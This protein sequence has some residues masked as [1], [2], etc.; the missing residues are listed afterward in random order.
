MINFLGQKLSVEIYRR[1]VVIT[2]LARYQLPHLM[3][4]KLCSI[5]WPR[6]LTTSLFLKHK[7]YFTLLVFDDLQGAR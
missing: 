4:D 7:F 1:G 3:K 5:R 2:A 6:R